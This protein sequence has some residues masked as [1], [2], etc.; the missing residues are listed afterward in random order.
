MK[1]VHNEL[2]GLNLYS[3][4]HKCFVEFFEYER[5]ANG[6]TTKYRMY[7]KDAST[8][9]LYLG[10]SKFIKEMS[11]EY[12]CVDCGSLTHVKLSKHLDE[13]IYIEC[14]CGEKCDPVI[15]NIHEQGE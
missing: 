11:C 10:R 7:D 8:P 15:G 5:F 9:M 3:E 4:Q 6:F 2:D 13:M 14:G 12:K 1:N